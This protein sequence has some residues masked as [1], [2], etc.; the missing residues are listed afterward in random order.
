[1]FTQ[2]SA[3]GWKT[4]G[5]SLSVAP[6]VL[7]VRVSPAL[8]ESSVFL[9]S[10]GAGAAWE[11]AVSSLQ[12]DQYISAHCTASNFSSYIKNEENKS[13]D[14]CYFGFAFILNYLLEVTAIFLLVRRQN[15]FVCAG[16]SY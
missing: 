9:S 13:Q 7:G 5:A 16:F 12:A 10:S 2:V 15:V 8:E 6:A 1:M 4:K 14:G 3:P 11:M